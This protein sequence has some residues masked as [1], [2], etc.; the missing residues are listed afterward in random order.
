MGGSRYVGRVGALAV[1]LGVGFAVAN[2]PGLAWADESTANG[3][4]PAAD[5][6]GADNTA[7]NEGEQ[8]SGAGSTAGPGTQQPNETTT[9]AVTTGGQTTTTTTIGAEGSPHVIIS[10][11]TIESSD[12]N[13]TTEKTPES[14]PPSAPAT[15]TP[16]AAPA[17]PQ[18]P[19]AATPA[20]TPT[21]VTSDSATPVAANDELRSTAAATQAPQSNPLI[22][23]NE[24]SG[25]QF[26]MRTVSL[27]G[28]PPTLTAA[29]LTSDAVTTLVD[30]APAPQPN[31]IEAV[32]AIP[33]TF[34]SQILGAVTNLFAPVIGP[35]A[36]ADN[37]LLWGLLAWVRR[38]F[39]Q[40]YANSTPAL[41]LQT[42]G[43]QDPDDRQIHGTLGGFDADG[44]VLTYS[45]TGEPAHGE[46][47]INAAAGTWTYTPDTAY[48]GTDTFT[49]TASDGGG[50][51][52]LHALGQT[53]SVSD[54][55]TVTVTDPNRP[56]VAVNDSA[57][58]VEGGAVT[59]NVLANDAD[60]DGNSTINRTTVVVSAPSQGTA[61]V[62]ATTGVITYTSNGAEGV[63]SDS[64]TYTVRDA[65]GAL[66]NTATVSITITPVNDGPPVANPDGPINVVEGGSVDVDVLAN[67]TDPDGNSTIDRSTVV[68]VTQP[69]HGTVTVNPTTGVIT[70]RSNG[71]EAT[72]DSFTYTVRDTANAVSLS[73]TVTLA[74]TAVDD[75][76]TAP[77]LTAT[78]DEDTPVGIIVVTPATDPDTP[79]T[80]LTVTTTAAPQQGTVSYNS[81]TGTL[82][83]TPNAQGL[84]AGQSRID[85]FTYTISDG[86]GGSDAGRIT[87]TVTGVNDAPTAT[88]TVSKPS[89]GVVTGNT[90]AT[91]IDGDTLT[92]TVESNPSKGTLTLNPDGTF[93]YEPSAQARIDAAAT[94][95]KDTDTFVVKIAD[96]RGA[97]VTKLVTVEVAPTGVIGEVSSSG[98]FV[99]QQASPAPNRSVIVSQTGGAS[100]TV[101]LTIFD[102][103]TGRQVGDTVALRGTT[104]QGVLWNA[105][106]TRAYFSAYDSTAGVS[107]LVVLD[108]ATGAQL[109]ATHTVQGTAYPD[110]AD[111]AQRLVFVG[112]QGATYRPLEVVVVD[113]ATGTQIGE[114]IR[115]TYSGTSNATV[116]YNT[117]RNRLVHTNTRYGVDGKTTVS[118]FDLTTGQQIGTSAIL[119][120]GGYA[121]ITPDDTRVVVSTGLYD[122]TG[123]GTSRVAVY[124]LAS[125]N[126]VGQTIVFDG[127]NANTLIGSDG[128]HAVTT[129]Y[130]Y[131][132]ATQQNTTRVAT[133]DVSTG[134]QIGSTRAFSGGF[135]NSY[136]LLNPDATRVVLRV[137]E[138]SESVGYTTRIIVLDTATGDQVG[139]TLS[140]AGSPGDAEFGIS[141]NALVLVSDGRTGV[142]RYVVLDPDT[143][144]QIGSTVTMNGQPQTS[145]VDTYFT[146]DGTRA[147]VVTESYANGLNVSVIDM[148]TGNRV[149]SNHV[150][151]LN[152]TFWDEGAFFNADGSR[153]TVTATNSSQ[154]KI[155]VFDTAT[156]ALLGT[157]T[158]AGTTEYSVKYDAVGARATQMTYDA[159]T[160]TTRLAVIDT[161]SGTQI[162]NTLVFA[163]QAWD[164]YYSDDRTMVSVT[165]S[166]PDKT[167]T[168]VALVDLATATQ[169]GQTFT[170][171]GE[172]SYAFFNPDGTRAVIATADAANVTRVVVIDTATG[173]PV[174][175][176][177]NIAGRVP[178]VYGAA[179]WHGTNH[180]VA[181]VQNP[182]GGSTTTVIEV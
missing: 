19:S 60:P 141:D 129:T 135:V 44:D 157:T 164:T 56:P 171:P 24:D 7:P 170:V 148:T 37:P 15:P 11:T 168:S 152:S 8:N 68:V 113:P 172:S 41:N 116:S 176:V 87:V 124:D 97:S 16:T 20:S 81:T 23:N 127:D 84:A 82:T 5:S 79:A 52:H 173:A 115:F 147:V 130:E 155:A 55:I 65:R 78:T 101:D 151:G 39:N 63:T 126:Q 163:G 53:H 21:P 110:Y 59:I 177:L 48:S 133:I 77:D 17:P 92:Y 49:I 33:G 40:A 181:P 179:Q 9:T 159:G 89:F 34:V 42:T 4:A 162:G 95:V 121:Q 138:G 18:Q 61:T 117:D 3:D 13:I 143:G 31:L 175:P 47:T 2:S 104:Q 51:F 182:S 80:G 96:G 131:N 99:Y 167:A 57:T 144:T 111:G 100:P 90:V 123:P 72:T 156:G 132:S 58:A 102:P 180:V 71:A 108:G 94:K 178:Y 122:P 128:V 98:T 83:Y 160:D 149:G 134:T 93:R 88:P 62:D 161:A 28:P 70:Y 14:T 43:Q 75:A 153:A 109:G 91:D 76:P 106:G 166:N 1:A 118:I 30:P 27:A 69:T 158:V 25:P 66:S 107:R 50:A 12:T 105:D 154:T 6:V 150:I 103:T 64:F 35:G 120:G 125:G 45:V 46:V 38:Q 174:L 85:V 112:Q 10:G 140:F 86:Q 165:T 145:F 142:T 22:E 36:P 146:P 73:A 29:D 119:D 26:N 67:D 139:N 54:T 114:R 74:I 137:Q 136:N 32:L 169:I